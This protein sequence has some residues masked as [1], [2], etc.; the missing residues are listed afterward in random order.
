[1]IIADS[2][3]VSRCET[4]YWLLAASTLSFLLTGCGGG[5]DFSKPPAQLQG[6]LANLQS[7]P[8]ESNPAAA[9]VAP[10][11]AGDSNTATAQA[12]DGATA[13]PANESMPD[14]AVTSSE[15][16]P[17]DPSQASADLP[18]GVAAVPEGPTATNIANSPD[19]PNPA[20]PAAPAPAVAPADPSAAGSET[21]ASPMPP[22]DAPEVMTASGKTADAIAAKKAANSENSVMGNAG[23]LLGSLKSNAPASTNSATPGAAANPDATNIVTRFGRTALTRVQWLQLVSQLTRQFF[24]AATP[25]ANGLAGS[26]GERSLEIL[27]TQLDLR[28]QTLTSPANGQTPTEVIPIRIPV[29][30]L[31]GIINSIEL[32][33]DG[34]YVLIGTT[35][36]RLLAR[37]AASTA[38]WDLFA[39][40]LFLF[41]DEHRRTA[42]LSKTALV[43]I[44]CLPNDQILTID[45]DGICSFWKLSDVVLPVTPIL[46]MTVE[47]AKAT[48]PEIVTATPITS[49]PV[50]GFEVLSIRIDDKNKLGAIVTSSEEAFLFRLETGALIETLKSEHFADTQP[51]CVDF[52]ADGTEILAGLADG[53][54]LRRALTGAAPVAGT[55]DQGE[56]V[57]YDTVFVPDVQDQVSSITSLLA[58]TDST[59]IYFG[60]I[61]GNVIRYDSALKRITQLEKRHAAPVIGFCLTSHGVLSIGADRQVQLFDAPITTPV[62]DPNAQTTF[63]LPKDETL[64]EPVVEDN[65]VAT[66]TVKSTRPTRTRVTPVNNPVDRG[67][68]WVRPAD[69]TL[70]LYE[71]QLRVAAEP[72][73]RLELQK[74]I[75]KHRGADSLADSL[76]KEPEEVPDGPPLRVGE[77]TTQLLFDS[78]NW[79]RVLMAVSDDETTIA[80]LHRGTTG[81]DGHQA[82]GALGLFDVTTETT[83]R[84]WIQPVATSRLSLN[85]PHHVVL[86]APSSTRFWHT[87]GFAETDPL[88]PISASVVSA[89]GNTVILGNAGTI[90]L[91]QPS[92]TRLDLKGKSETRGLELFETRISSAAFTSAGDRLLIGTRERDL[93]RLLELDPNTFAIQQ[94][95]ARETLNGRISDNQQETSPKSMPGTVV[96]QPSPSDKMMATWGNYDGGSQLRIWKRSGAK[97]T[98]DNVSVIKAPEAAPDLDA[99]D[100][101]MTFVNRQDGRLAIVT[102]T[103][104]LILSTRKVEV[105]KTIPIP[106]IGG[107][108]PPCVFTP[109]GLWLLAGDNDGNVWAASLQSLDR[110]PI[111][112]AAHVGPVAGL[113]ISANGRFLA[114][115]GEDNRLRSWRVDGFLKR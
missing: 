105:E 15:T 46:E 39:R 9:E 26:T 2:T 61:D 49:F 73:K 33:N 68:A 115:I 64:E 41:Q 80:L 4:R 29:A 38:D 54:I 55:N 111:K 8:T 87:S 97:W 13:A 48:D 14:P 59:T 17:A 23:G 1:M 103:G 47:Q 99:I 100:Q 42:R 18:S 106:S 11:A 12:A 74:Q 98:T 3:R 66:P 22:G 10:A 52:V 24:V 110:K 81:R 25:D 76:G 31:R 28:S 21:A 72:A 94:E 84:Y 60:T 70:A 53:R 19:A 101:P 7:D 78:G 6:R 5:E 56:T 102:S 62:T 63:Q 85:A 69:S 92:L 71:H 44:R 91:A 27:D 50:S 107:H 112:F 90:A 79:S 82:K 75:L 95:I 16:K 57:D 40:D 77:T 34:Q 43:A 86:P 45:A 109:D 96:I 93:V 58:V 89:D 32:T 67:A 114:T 65:G 104:L 30:G 35:D 108:R 113:A 36:G 20:T 88:R 37:S 51:V 83:L